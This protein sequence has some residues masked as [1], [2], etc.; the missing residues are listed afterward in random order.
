[1]LGLLIKKQTVLHCKYL[2]KKGL[3]QAVKTHA[4]IYKSILLLVY[5][6]YCGLIL[7]SSWEKRRGGFQRQKK[8]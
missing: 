8:F 6:K 3:S 2:T 5:I 4:W 7:M 1:M